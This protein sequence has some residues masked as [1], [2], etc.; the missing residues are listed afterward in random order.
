MTPRKLTVTV[1][2][3][4]TEPD[5]LTVVSF[6]SFR[7]FATSLLSEKD[8]NHVKP[9][10]P[11]PPHGHKPLSLPLITPVA[12]WSDLY[13]LNENVTKMSR[14]FFA[15]FDKVSPADF[16]AILES[17]EGT[18]ALFFTTWNNYQPVKDGLACFRIV[19]ELDRPY[20]PDEYPA[21]H[22]AVSSLFGGLIDDTTAKPS[23]GYFVPVVRPDDPETFVS[24]LFDGAPLEV[25][26]LLDMNTDTPVVPVPTA[27]TTT[28]HTT[29]KA[30]RGHISSAVFTATF[31]KRAK[32]RGTNEKRLQ[33]VP[34]S[35]CVV[36]LLDGTVPDALRPGLGARHDF[37]LSLAGALAAW[38]PEV[39]PEGL[40][41][42]LDGPGWAL[43][44]DGDEANHG[45]ERFTGMIRDFQHKEHE[46]RN[47][48]YVQA[49]ASAP[50][51]KRTELITP[52][53]TQ[54]LEVALGG[55]GE[56]WRK[57]AVLQHKSAYFFMKEDGTYHSKM[58]T[59][60]E[61]L[62][63]ARDRFAGFGEEVSIH[64]QNE[65][66]ER[67]MHTL[68]S[69]LQQYG[70]AVDDVWYD[71]TIAASKY[72]PGEASLALACAVPVVEPIYDQTINDFL[73]GVGGDIFLDMIAAMG[74][75]DQ[76]CPGMV[77][78]G[79]GGS[80]KTLVAMALA[81]IWGSAPLRAEDAHSQ[82][83]ATTMLRQPITLHDEKAGAAYEREGTS[84]V[85]KNLT[86]RERWV[87]EKFMPKIRM[88]GYARLIFAANN[89]H[90]L[91]TKENM[92]KADREAFAE[93]LVHI[94]FGPE[95]VEYLKENLERTQKE[96]IGENKLASHFLWLIQNR[97]I[98]NKGERF[99]VQAPRTAL[100]DS[101]AGGSG[102]AAEC[103][104]WL[105]CYVENPSPMNNL[106]APGVQLLPE[107][108]ELRVIAQSVFAH[109]NTYL[110]GSKVP[111]L[112]LI[113]KAVASISLDARCKIRATYS[114]G[115]TKYQSARS[116]DLD[117][118]RARLDMHHLS[119]EDFN[120]TLGFA[121]DPTPPDE[122][123]KVLRDT[124][125]PNLRII[126]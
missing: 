41:E 25:D 91:D 35:R 8:E 78:T 53:E 70:T 22:S 113:Q 96:W 26:V 61:V 101:I 48:R 84:L 108:Q 30:M 76:M 54:A 110:E 106:A 121:D 104:Q 125:H 46:F 14:V 77:M 126:S 20:T 29:E 4:I 117:M 2:A 16:D 9:G 19:L 87:E 18:S 13:R 38:W 116:I 72:T 86:E 47:V 99:L 103:M 119:L 12:E 80:G 112:S 81:M 28:H 100:H 105:L 73:E 59:K 107:K 45:I 109:W 65:E 102:V 49:L 95:Q 62:L 122:D 69:F 92:S 34:I 67:K 39:S 10:D 120:E 51:N 50:M 75:L 55:G 5:A 79:D 93:R 60:D 63:A 33:R 56:D 89:T 83:N 37:M 40:A 1:C 17:L 64:Y 111:N 11:I 24:E 6:P 31:R 94:E 32:Y 124:K 36:S 21:V 118:L 15:D 97:E 123:E 57:C 98:V 42:H 27:P 43:F 58:W 74:R 23:L 3:S 71:Q 82:Y 114:D 88:I 68:G 44:V 7:D 52:E 66:G 90:I 115:T 85:R